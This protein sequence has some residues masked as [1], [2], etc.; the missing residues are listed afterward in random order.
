MIVGI[1]ID[2]LETSRIES[3]IGKERFLEKYY[4][5][6]EREQCSLHQLANNF[7]AKEAVAKAF[8]LGFRCFALSDLEILRDR[9]GKPYVRLCG[10][11]RKVAMRM[12]IKK[13]HISISD[14]KHYIT[15]TAVIER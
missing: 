12:R 10:N 4:T 6:K 1:G 8:G 2:I 15:A 5:V 14:T 7:V 3:A 13:V 9:Q 11:A